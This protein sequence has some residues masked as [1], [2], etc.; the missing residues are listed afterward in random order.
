MRF[1]GRAPREGI[2]V[3]PEHPLVEA[4]TLTI[5]LASVLIL[6]TVL[7]VKFVDVVILLISPATESR[8]FSTWDYGAYLHVDFA[9]ARV[10]G[11]EALTRRLARHW[12]DA[13]YDFRVGVIEDADPNALALPG[14][15][16]V[17]TNG[18]LDQVES[19]NELAFVLGHE[20]GH[21]RNRDHLR[22]LGRGFALGLLTAVVA[23]EDGGMLSSGVVE[24]T[25]RRFSRQQ[26]EAADLFA[27]ELL[28]AEYGHVADATRFFERLT[29]KGGRTGR[30]V[31]YFATHP[32]AADRVEH[33]RAAAATRGW[34]TTGE[35]R[36]L[37]LRPD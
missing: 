31:G 27:L 18:L 10:G 7:A 3:S 25:A 15:T 12:P 17:V 34:P 22:Q 19:E 32:L 28:E 9:D 4:L 26:E 14:G 2:N 8:V 21:F 29:K 1:V 11:L 6:V 23:G 16:I 5:G 33:L 36:P 20:I 13:Y 35:T 24:G 30:V 37:D